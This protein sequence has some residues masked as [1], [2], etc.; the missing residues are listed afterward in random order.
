MQFGLPRRWFRPLVLVFALALPVRAS[1]GQA[2]ERLFYYVDKEDSYR[3]LIR[4]IDQI[5]ILGPQVYTVDSLGIVFGELDARVL[6]LAKAHHIKVMPLVVN[7]G[8]NQ[9]ALRKLLADTTARGRATRSLADLCRGN[10]Y[11]GIQFDIEN[12]NIQDRDLLSAWYRETA[13]AL[14]R[15]SCTLS[16]AVVHRT[17]ENA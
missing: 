5:T 7:E 12:V 4:N 3:S 9:P 11:W 16:I 2:L 8:F 17:D 14:H 13:N 10:A 1:R 15:V 6:A